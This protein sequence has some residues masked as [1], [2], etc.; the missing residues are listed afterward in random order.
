MKYLKLFLFVFSLFILSS[1]S[2]LD[3]DTRKQLPLGCLI[4]SIEI[5]YNIEAKARLDKVNIWTK[6]INVKLKG[7]KLGHAFC[8]YEYNN[9]LYCYNYT[10][11][12]KILKFNIKNPLS[13]AYQVYG[14]KNIES[15]VFLD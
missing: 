12:S 6:I 8:V 11:G 1:C 3:W 10:G 7:S 14:I 9:Q 4:D 2:S 15:A 13:I 5:K